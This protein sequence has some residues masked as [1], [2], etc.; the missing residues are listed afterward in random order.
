[1]SEVSNASNLPGGHSAE[2]TMFQL[3]GGDLSSIPVAN[4]LNSKNYFKW[5]QIVRT[6]LKGKGKQSHILRNGPKKGDPNF[7]QVQVQVLCKEKL[8]PLEEVIAVVIAEESRRTVMLNTQVSSGSAMI[9]RNGSVRNN[10]QHQ[11]NKDDLF[12]SY[13]KKPRHTREKCWKLHGK[14]TNADYGNKQKSSHSHM[15]TTTKPD[16][17]KSQS[18]E[19]CNQ[20]KEEWKSSSTNA[21]IY[22][23]TNA[24]IYS[25]MLPFSIG[26][27]ASDRPS[28]IIDSGATDHMT[29][30]SSLFTTYSPCP[31]SRKVATADGSLTTVAGIGDVP[32]SSSLI[33]RN[34]LHVPKLST[35]LISIQKLTHDLCCQATF[36][37]TYCIFQDK[38]SG[39]RIGRAK[40]QDG[41]YYLELP[42]Q[43]EKS[44]LHLVEESSSHKGKF[45]LHHYRLGHA[46]F[47]I[48]KIMFPTLFTRLT[49]EEF[50][51]DICEFAKHKRTNFPI[52]NSR[53]LAPFQLVHSDVWGP[54]TTPNV[55]GA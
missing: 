36:S 30:Q 34:V 4:R 44:S 7:D 48:L 11:G 1:M 23:G 8:P 43:H 20:G 42:S 6:L 26:F 3:T 51:C 21:A 54:S 25:G 45:W 39:K 29:Y 24:T 55:S 14:P 13:C 5:S 52:S 50:H 10:A 41:L 22:S 40:E 16:E 38:D 53:S 37:D 2:T 9:S 31:S 17:E 35:N 49:I 15:T 28:W 18:K 27:N 46:S 47:R 32:L 12:C 19:E 33:L